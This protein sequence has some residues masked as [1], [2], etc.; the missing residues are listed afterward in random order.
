M[1]QGSGCGS[2]G[3]R[4]VGR[5]AA[6][7][8]AYVRSFTQSFLAKDLCLSLDQ[9][10]GF[11]LIWLVLEQDPRD[12][13]PQPGLQTLA[14]GPVQKQVWQRFSACWWAIL[15]SMYWSVCHCQVRRTASSLIHRKGCSRLERRAWGNTSSI[16]A[17]T[18]ALN[19]GPGF[20]TVHAFTTR[21]PL[22]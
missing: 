18:S 19:K 11:M 12:H 5:G 20:P 14:F 2:V 9:L 21:S 6:P 17:S 15:L 7:L 22:R 1:L 16:A 10:H 8:P 3:R 13:Q 4:G